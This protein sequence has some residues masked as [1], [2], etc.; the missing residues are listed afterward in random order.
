MTFSSGTVEGLNH[1]I[2]LAGKKISK[3]EKEN[4]LQ[5][6]AL[7]ILCV[8]WL[9]LPTAFVTRLSRSFVENVFI[10][11]PLLGFILWGK[12]WLGECRWSKPVLV[13]VG[14]FT[15]LTVFA[16]FIPFHPLSGLDS[17]RSFHVKFALVVLGIMFVLTKPPLTKALLW[18]FALAMLVATFWGLYQWILGPEAL[19][20]EWDGNPHLISPFGYNVNRFAAY[21]AYFLPVMAAAGFAFHKQ[22]VRKLRFWLT[23]YVILFLL[24]VFL[25][26]LTGSRASQGGFAAAV[27]CILF[28]LVAKNRCRKVWIALAVFFIVLWTGIFCLIRVSDLGERTESKWRS[29]PEFISDKRFT[30]VWPEHWEVLRP[31]KW[32]GLNFSRD[33]REKYIEEEPGLHEHSFYMEFFADS[34]LVG[35]AGLLVLALSLLG[36]GVWRLWRMDYG[37]HYLL[38]L[39]AMSSYLALL[40]RSTMDSAYTYQFEYFTA[41]LLGLVCIRK[42]DWDQDR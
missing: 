24:S 37:V 39:G 30:Q 42:V 22:S 3:K 16:Q 5:K 18:G 33:Q 7:V 36:A 2:N 41:L 17:V 35:L 11:T 27:I 23:P 38:L 9:L 40:A 1:K 6:M 29:S 8:L 25:L 32:F 28:G 26:I 12:G 13:A 34:G 21:L 31:Y 14:V 15:A 19:P 20:W 10:L 4:I